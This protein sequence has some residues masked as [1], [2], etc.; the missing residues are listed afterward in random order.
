VSC[1]ITALHLMDEILSLVDSP[2]SLKK[3]E[4]RCRIEIE[5]PAPLRSGELKDKTSNRCRSTKMLLI[6]LV[7]LRAG[8][9]FIKNAP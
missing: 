9:T 8:K 6:N 2:R 1:V 3:K 5:T 4:A 7:A